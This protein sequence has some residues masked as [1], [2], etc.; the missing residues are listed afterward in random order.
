MLRFDYVR[1]GSR[2]REARA[3]FDMKGSDL[4]TLSLYVGV[5]AATLS[6]VENGASKF[7]LDTFVK[8]VDWMGGEWGE[9][10]NF[11]ITTEG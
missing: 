7:D 3:S 11:L 2:V 4:R 10:K 1:F 8:L 6:R 9:L 5:S